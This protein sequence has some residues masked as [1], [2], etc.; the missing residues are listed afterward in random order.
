M[1]KLLN[2]LTHVP[3]SLKYL[4]PT[5]ILVIGGIISGATIYQQIDLFQKKFEA[6]ALET[7]DLDGKQISTLLDYFY[8]REAQLGD[9]GINLL[10]SQIA[11]RPNLSTAVLLDQSDTVVTATDYRLRGEPFTASSVAGYAGLLSDVDSRQVGKTTLIPDESKVVSIYPVVLGLEAGELSPSKTG[12]ILLVYDYAAQR[13]IFIRSIIEK[14]LRQTLIIILPVCLLIWV[15]SEVYITRRAAHL[16][17]ASKAL[18]NGNLRIRPHLSGADE[19]AK[20]SVAFAQMAERIQNDTEMLQASEAELR[21]Q[22]E[23]IAQTL[24]DLQQ[25]QLQIIQAEK[26]SSLGQLVAGVAHEINNPIGCIIGNVGAIQVYID[27]LLGLLDL[28]AEELPTP[29]PNLEEEL[30]AVDL[31]YVREDLPKLIR[32]MQDSGTRIKAISRGL[33]TFSRADTETK[34]AFD[35]HEGLDSTIL[36]LRHRLKPNE[37]RPAIEVVKAYGDVPHIDCFPGQLNQVFM[38]ILANAIDA[39]DDASQQR[40]FAEIEEDP[41]RITIQTTLEHQQVKVV[42]SDNGPGIPE[43][44]RARIFEHL[45]TTKEAGKGTG[46]GLAIA[47]KIVVESHGGSIEVDAETGK[48]TQFLIHL[49]V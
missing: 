2:K 39:L 17:A 28:Y 37:Q 41:N 8:R 45:F 9:N 14:T 47:H 32:A 12:A 11:N 13:Q 15:L 48:G 16:V 35:L 24:Q 30:E 33:R 31:E 20:I 40:T 25:A 7:A 44:A 4:I 46:L 3:F 10:V 34:Q 19:L 38:N 22:S 49:P 5:T 29:S 18:A 42:I 21:T 26:M 23:E 27:D 36:I 6:D 43:S 1:F